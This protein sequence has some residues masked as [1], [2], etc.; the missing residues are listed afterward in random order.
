MMLLWKEN[1]YDLPSNDNHQIMEK[2]RP[3]TI[4]HYTKDKW[5]HYYSGQFLPLKLHFL[6]QSQCY[7]PPPW[8]YHVGKVCLCGALWSEW[9]WEK[10]WDFSCIFRLK[11]SG[12]ICAWFVNRWSNWVFWSVDFLWLNIIVVACIKHNSWCWLIT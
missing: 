8:N 2:V 9:R 3:C 7:Q 11:K 12:W 1:A 10:L 4:L 6:W 5:R